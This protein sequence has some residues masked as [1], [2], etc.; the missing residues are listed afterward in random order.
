MDDLTDAQLAELTADLNALLASLEATA[1]GTAA[2]AGTVHLD[3]AAVGRISRVDALQAQKI[4]EAQQ[5]RSELRRKQVL[6]ALQAVQDGEYG[7]CKVCGDPIG[8][9]RLKARPE[10]PACV[11]CM[12]ELER[13]HGPT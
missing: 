7:D 10:S 1:R 8:Y 2:L 3:Q 13:R 9:D 12:V 6:V 11:R 4:A 5:R